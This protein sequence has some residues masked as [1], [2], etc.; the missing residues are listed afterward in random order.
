[1]NI[2]KLIDSVVIIV[3]GISLIIFREK[4]IKITLTLSKW[5][6][7]K[8]RFPLYKVQSENTDSVSMR[9]GII[10]VAVAFIFF[11]IAQLGLLQ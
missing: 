9:L 1:M 4:Y 11:G 8:T 10:L 7:K 5:L 2:L 3:A 6:F